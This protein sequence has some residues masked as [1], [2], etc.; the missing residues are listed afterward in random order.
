[1]PCMNASGDMP[2]GVTRG[3]VSPPATRFAADAECSDA[4]AGFSTR[5]TYAAGD[6]GTA[7]VRLFGSFQADHIRTHGKRRAVAYAKSPNPLS[8]SR[9]AAWCAFAQ[10]GEPYSVTSTGMPRACSPS[11]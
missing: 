5:R 1:M 10:P 8:G 11:S 7:N 6:T 4:Y 9:F 3:E 2:L